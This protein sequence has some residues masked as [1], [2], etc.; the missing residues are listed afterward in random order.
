MNGMRREWERQSDPKAV[1]L[2][3][4]VLSSS[5]ILGGGSAV[6]AESR[7]GLSRTK[8]PFEASGLPVFARSLV[9]SDRSLKIWLDAS[10]NVNNSEFRPGRI[11]MTQQDQTRV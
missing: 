8:T 6:L 3:E 7:H 4:E 1:R 10:Q 5:R 9:G 2:P 11:K